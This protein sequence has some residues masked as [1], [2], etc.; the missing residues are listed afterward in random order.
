M[1]SLPPVP[2]EERVWE[3]GGC[4]ALRVGTWLGNRYVWKGLMRTVSAQNSEAGQWEGREQRCAWVQFSTWTRFSTMR[5]AGKGGGC[6]CVGKGGT[7]LLLLLSAEMRTDIPPPS[8][9]CVNDSSVTPVFLVL[10]A[11]YHL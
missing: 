6:V 10:F 7:G 11:L 5:G 9:A 8:S 1:A 2:G 4:E 3:E